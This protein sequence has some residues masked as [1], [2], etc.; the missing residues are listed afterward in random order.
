[1]SVTT[2]VYWI[3]IRLRDG[4]HKAFL[5]IYNR[6]G[7]TLYYFAKKFIQDTDVIDDIVHD[8]FLNLWNARHR[9]KSEYPIE[10]YLFRI[11]RNL[12][13]KH[14]KSQLKSHEALVELKHFE[15]KRIVQQSA[16]QTVIEEEYDGIYELAIERLPPQRKKIFMMCREE[17]LS[18]KEIAQFLNISPN[19]VKEHMSLA[20]K[21]IQDYIAK[22]HG[23]ILSLVFVLLF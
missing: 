6:H 20:M 4:D 7:K 19:T 9:I 17:G 18:H 8:S 16:E 5:E 14:L 1:M 13:F 12:V 21:T 23:V 15:E 10:N 22:D 2:E 3:N 11:V